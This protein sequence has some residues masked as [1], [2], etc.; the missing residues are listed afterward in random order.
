MHQLFTILSV[1]AWA[2]DKWPAAVFWGLV[3][4]YYIFKEE[5]K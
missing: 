2:N 5:R 3:T 1:I 4:V